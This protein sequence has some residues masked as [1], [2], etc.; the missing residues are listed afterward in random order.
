MESRQINLPN[1]DSLPIRAT[2]TLNNIKTI[3]RLLQTEKPSTT[4][5]IGLAFGASALAILATQKELHGEGSFEHVS[6]DPYQKGA[7]KSAAIHMIA[8]A[9]LDHS[10][11]HIAEDSALALPQLVRDQ[12]S[13][14]LIYVDGSHIF[15]NVFVDFFFCSRLLSN[16]GLMLFDDSTDK[17]VRKVLKFIDSNYSGILQRENV[18]DS[19][20]LK[21]RLGNSL[22]IR[23]LTVYRKIGNPPRKWDTAFQNF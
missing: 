18:V 20:T 5:E 23:Q 21:Q 19:P 6:I 13:F 4:L 7:W 17:H 16:N 15:E 9:G 14:G 22:G 3:R 2:S 8:E 1:G 11:T 12:K 10:F